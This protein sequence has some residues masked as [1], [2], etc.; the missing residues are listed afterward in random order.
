MLSYNMQMVND[1]AAAIRSLTIILDKESLGGDIWRETQH[2]L[3]TV[4]RQISDLNLTL[5]Q[6]QADIRFYELN[7][8]PL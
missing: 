3:S 4:N 2:K 1:L 8:E 7:T 5:A 6:I